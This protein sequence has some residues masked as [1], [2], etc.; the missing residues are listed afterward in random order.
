VLL[1]QRDELVQNRPPAISAPSLRK[2]ML[3]GSRHP[4]A[5]RLPTGCFQEAEHLRL[6]LS[7]PI[8]QDVTMAA[9]LREGFPQLRD[10]PFWGG[11]GRYVAMQ[12]LAPLGLDDKATIQPSER[13]RRHGEASEGGDS[14]AVIREKGAPLL[15][16]IPTPNPTT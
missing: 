16:G 12:N 2:A 7:V 15:T 13:R 9:G 4:G 1:L 6:E 10:D 3:P 14:R 8:E 5:F 11:M